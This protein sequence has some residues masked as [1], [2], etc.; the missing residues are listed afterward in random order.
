LYTSR[1]LNTLL[2]IHKKVTY[3]TQST[4]LYTLASPE[5]LDGGVTGDTDVLAETGLL[6]AVDLANVEAALHL[7]SNLSPVGG[8]GLAVMA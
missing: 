8:H 4:V 3:T 2:I 6:L 7:A 5:E 1:N